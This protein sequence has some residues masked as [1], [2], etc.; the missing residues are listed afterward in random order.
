MIL[1]ALQLRVHFIFTISDNAEICAWTKYELKWPKMLTNYFQEPIKSMPY[2]VTSKI[3][4]P[5]F[6]GF[7]FARKRYTSNRYSTWW[8]HQMETF[9]SLLALCAG[10][11]Q[12][13]GEFPLQKPVTRS[14]DFFLV[15]NRDAGD[16]RRHWVHYDVTIMTV[17]SWTLSCL[18]AVTLS[19][20]WFLL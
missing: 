15:N 17:C 9:A 3:N 5:S 20:L 7:F 19:S 13:P 16:L 6:Q 2:C 11:S 4:T 1:T 12:V 8:R 14:F 10:N 18:P